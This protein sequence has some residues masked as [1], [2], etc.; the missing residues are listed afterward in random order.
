MSGREDNPYVWEALAK[1]KAK[2]GDDQA[3]LEALER[4]AKL[5][6]GDLHIKAKLGYAYRR[7]GRL[8]DAIRALRPVL[9]KNP[10]DPVLRRVVL[11]TYRQA[12]RLAEAIA[13]CREIACKHSGGSR[14]LSVSRRL[15]QLLRCQDEDRE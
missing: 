12:G 15:Q 13:L 5:A 4:A 8:D 14:Y 6:P 1:K 3:A 10:L 7:V 11:R 2:A 9:F